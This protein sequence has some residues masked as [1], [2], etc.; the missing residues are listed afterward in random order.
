MFATVI[1]LY[2]NNMINL[3][4]L[5]QRTILR[6]PQNGDRI[7]TIDSVTSLHLV[8]TYFD[9]FLEGDVGLEERFVELQSVVVPRAE[10]AVDRLHSLAHRAAKLC[11]QHNFWKSAPRSIR[12]NYLAIN[13]KQ[14]F[15]DSVIL[16]RSL[17]VNQKRSEFTEFCNKPGF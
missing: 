14:V 9:E 1:R 16:F 13:Q 4:L 12:R 11:V 8:H 2:L 7:V 5:T 10:S 6:Y 3:R 15:A 17:P